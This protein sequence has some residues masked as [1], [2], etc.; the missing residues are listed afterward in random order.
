[1]KKISFYIIFLCA[2]FIIGCCPK[3]APIFQHVDMSENIK[4]AQEII[5]DSISK[6]DESTDI[7]SKKAKKII[8]ITD[9]MELRSQQN[10]EILSFLNGISVSAS[11]ILQANSI[12]SSTINNLKRARDNIKTISSKAD[13]QKKQLEKLEKY[14][15]ALEESKKKLLEESS[16]K[17]K[18]AMFWL[19]ISCVIG[20]GISV[21]L[22]LYGSRIGIFGVVSCVVTLVVAIAIQQ[23]Y[24]YFAIIGVVFLVII[25]GAL[26]YN[27]FVQ[28][29]ANMEF[30]KTV[31]I[32]KDNM[33]PNQKMKIFGD[34]GESGVVGQIQSKS[35]Q[36]IVGKTKKKIRTVWDFFKQES[37]N[38][39]SATDIQNAE[40]NK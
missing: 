23:F 22:I 15:A 7:I 2:I 13:T 25:I 11:D 31:E 6:T 30:I 38:S 40:S 20:I 4:N 3:S 36:Q 9:Q 1:V 34:V 10:P 28:K 39:K 35:T 18:E 8:S 29:R 16:L 26:L 12:I 14:N 21:A 32:A 19:T 5:G 37:I 27:V 24:M 33:T 17:T